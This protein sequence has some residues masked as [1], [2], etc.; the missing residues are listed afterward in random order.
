MLKKNALLVEILNTKFRAL[1]PSD[2]GRV[3]CLSKRWTTFTISN[4]FMEGE[5]L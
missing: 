5:V 3:R 1:V 4:M 2:E